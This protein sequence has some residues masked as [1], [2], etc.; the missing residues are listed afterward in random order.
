MVSNP[1]NNYVG[2]GDVAGVADAISLRNYM[3]GYEQ[4]I[5]KNMGYPEIA[6]KITKAVQPE[7][8]KAILQGF[9]QN[10]RKPGV[11]A[12]LED[13]LEIVP[14]QITAPRDMQ[15]ESGW[16]LMREDI[17]AGFGVPLSYFVQEGGARAISQ[18]DRER[19]AQ[20]AV[21]PELTR[22]AEKLNEQLIPKY[23]GGDYFLWFDDPVPENRELELEE[24]RVLV[25]AGIMSIDEA[26]EKKRLEPLGGFAA[27]PT[28]NA[29]RKPLSMAGEFGQAGVQSEEE[30]AAQLSRVMDIV[31]A[32]R[33]RG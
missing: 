10:Y 28:I 21:L 30:V 29:N 14:L 3:T 26:R 4:S 6:L 1:H 5:F 23:D 31:R 17:V 7:Q 13:W 8:A 11:V 27:E 16:N 2:M 25:D 20:N 22:Q 15:Y 9:K 12:L 19:F 32:Q 24:L 33:E 18:S